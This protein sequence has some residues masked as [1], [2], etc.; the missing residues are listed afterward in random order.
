MVKK[1]IGDTTRKR[2]EPSL[3]T[4]SVKIINKV[5]QLL[6]QGNPSRS[7]RGSKQF[8]ETGDNKFLQ[9]RVGARLRQVG[10]QQVGAGCGK[11]SLA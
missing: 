9:S 2:N 1:V 6:Q 11:R 10:G 3:L 5:T 7:I 8:D 4:I